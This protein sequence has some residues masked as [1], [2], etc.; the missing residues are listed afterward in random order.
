[1]LGYESSLKYLKISVFFLLLLYFVQGEKDLNIYIFKI[2]LYW[3][4]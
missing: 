2:S 4:L 1:M 3:I